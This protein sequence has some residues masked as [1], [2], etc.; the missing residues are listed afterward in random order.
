MIVADAMNS[1]AFQQIY[2]FQQKL[3]NFIGILQRNEL[4]KMRVVAVLMITNFNSS[5]IKLLHSV[6]DHFTGRP[7]VFHGANTGLPAV[8]NGKYA[9]I[10]LLLCGSSSSDH[11]TCCLDVLNHIL[12]WRLYLMVCSFP[13]YFKNV[14]FGFLST[15]WYFQSPQWFPGQGWNT[16]ISSQYFLQITFAKNSME[17]FIALFPLEWKLFR[18]VDILFAFRRHRPP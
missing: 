5:G 16:N 14:R 6:L 11:Y 7:L 12:V 3:S 15:R 8:T 2:S 17:Q 10:F 13:V 4:K 1:L 18:V 9:D